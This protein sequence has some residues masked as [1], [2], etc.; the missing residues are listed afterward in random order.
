MSNRPFKFIEKAGVGWVLAVFWM[1]FSCGCGDF[2]AEKPTEIQTQV[3]LN[4]LRQIKENPNVKNPLPEIYRGPAKR[5]KVKNGVKLFYFAKHHVVAELSAL[6]NSQFATVHTDD[7]GKTYTVPDYPVSD[8]YSTNQLIIHCPS[9]QEV[10]KIEEFLELVD[11]PPIQ[12]NID[13]IVLERFADVTMDWETT[14]LIENLL[15][16]RITLGGKTD[17][18]GN[19]LPAFP[20]ASLR[21]SRRADFGLDFGYWRN[22]GIVGHQFRAVVDMLISRGYLKILMNPTL[23]TVNGK[24]AAIVS[25]EY[26]P[27]EKIVT[28]PGVEPYS[29]TEYQWVVDTLEVTPHVFVDGSI[30]LATTIKLGSRSKPEG[31]VQTSI[32]TERSISIAEN[33]I[34]PGLSLIVGGIRK[35]E[36]RAVVRGVPFLK[37]IPIIGIL[38]SSKDFEEKSTEVIFILTPSISSGGVEYTKMV[39]DVKEKYAPPKYKLGLKEAL[40]APF[41]GGVY[42]ELVEQQ[43]ARAEFER[44]KSDIEKLDALEEVDL[45]KEKLLEKAEEVLVE[46]A[47]AAKAIAEARAA[48]AEAEKAKAERDKIKAE[49]GKNNIQSK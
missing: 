44:F 23:E 6:V 16:E 4:E 20:G 33:R 42:T 3:I 14:I 39:E 26:A 2:F 35:S 29:L 48:K 43:A 11:V 8:S 21:E 49:N 32:I 13:C 34:K 47:K 36:E 45:I 41:G 12:V 22:Q 40:T 5:I 10:D 38:F 31:V 46:K 18:V 15:G 28:P 30:S 25:R 7:G 9:E 17:V 1:L 27:L 24:P 37:D 19:I